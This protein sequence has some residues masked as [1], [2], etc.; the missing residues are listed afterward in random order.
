MDHNKHNLKEGDTVNLDSNYR[1]GSKVVILKFTPN[2]LFAE[3]YAVGEK[4]EDSW[5]T[6]TARLEPIIN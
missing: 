1:N 4:P 3:I 5:S 6:M 2:K